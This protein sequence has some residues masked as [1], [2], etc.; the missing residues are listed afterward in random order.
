M[1]H[2][3]CKICRGAQEEKQ[4]IMIHFSWPWLALILPLP[5][6]LRKYLPPTKDIQEAVLKVP[7]ADDFASDN[8]QH[9]QINITSWLLYLAAIAWLLLVV[10]AMRPQWLGDLVEIPVTGRDLMMAID[11]SG[12]MQEKDFLLDGR[13]VDRL[14]ATKSIAGDFINRRVG[15]RIGLILFGEQAYLQAPLTFDRDTV[16]ELLNESFIGLAG[17]KTAIGDAIGLAIKRLRDEDENS[18]LLILL[19]D[20]ANTAGEVDPLNSA[21]LAA[22]EGIKIYTIG[23]GADEMIVKSFFGSRRVNPSADLDEATLKSIAEKTGGQYFRAHDVKELE[24]IYALLDELEPTEK[25]A[26][27]YRPRTAL[28]FWPLSIALVLTLIILIAKTR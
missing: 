4:P 25:S 2:A 24:D 17:K 9:S 15:D 18:R 10:A 28:Y 7:F 26:Q 27:K 14:T 8:S 6:L 3:D 5:W 20:G 13:R 19:T 11:L 21:D 23:V 22:T 1:D 16:N 12:S